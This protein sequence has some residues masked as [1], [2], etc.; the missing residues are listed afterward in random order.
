VFI[1]DLTSNPVVEARDIERIQAP[2]AP[3]EAAAPPQA[4]TGPP[5]PLAPRPQPNLFGDATAEPGIHPPLA[6]WASHTAGINPEQKLQLSASALETYGTCPQK[7]MFSHYLKIST[8]PQPA[9]TFG[10]IMHHCVR[11]FF[12]LRRQGPV[13]FEQIQAHFEQVWKGTGFE[14]DYQEQAYKKAGLEQL[15]VF[16]SQH[17]NVTTLP[18]AAEAHFSLD[19]G[20][21]VLEGRI[22]QIN[23]LADQSVELVDYKTGR[24]PS[25]KDA[26]KSLQ[27]SVYALAARDQLHLNPT[28]LTFYSLTNNEPVRTVR[29]SKSLDLVVGDIRGVA[30]QIRK[31]SFPPKP[32][33]ACKYC[34]YELICPA[35]E[36]SF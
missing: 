21:V 17:E 27:L 26:D 18:L 14:D 33:F 9:L 7:F 19:L 22:D 5:R 8:G 3:P 25:Q 36:E 16:V 31:Q 32:G 12:E 35:H 6:R 15:R 11:H 1:S 23:P 30:E 2:E 10:N 34:D 20:D 28:R 13:K 24:P 29:T 4:E